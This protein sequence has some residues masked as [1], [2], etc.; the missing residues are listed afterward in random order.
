MED[1]LPIPAN[2]LMYFFLHPA[3]EYGNRKIWLDRIPKYTSVGLQ[4]D[5]MNDLIETSWGLEIVEYWS[6]RKIINSAFSVV[7]T[8]AVLI[9]VLAT[10][11]NYDLRESL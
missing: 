6:G 10:L 9:G 3:S 7:G 11:Y 4:L 1:D 2:I 8:S 5:Q